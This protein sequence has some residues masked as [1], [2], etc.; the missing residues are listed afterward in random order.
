MSSPQLSVIIVSY[1][2]KYF[3]RQCLQSVERALEGSPEKS[4]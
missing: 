1:N 2:V 3:L 4:G